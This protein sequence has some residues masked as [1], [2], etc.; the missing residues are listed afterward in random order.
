MRFGKITLAIVLTAMMVIT[1]LLVTAQTIGS[2]S[3][4]TKKSSKEL[5]QSSG[6]AAGD[7]LYFVVDA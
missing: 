2:E 7:T 1:P 6:V 3:E 4:E 5:P